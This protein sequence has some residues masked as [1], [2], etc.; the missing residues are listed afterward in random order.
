MVFGGDMA[1]DVTS[2]EGM[3]V[4]REQAYLLKPCPASFLVVLLPCVPVVMLSLCDPDIAFSSGSRCQYRVSSP[5][6]LLFLTRML[7]ITY[8]L[9]SA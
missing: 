1:I 6:P 3:L 4:I 9:G 2:S 7:G 5:S 8:L